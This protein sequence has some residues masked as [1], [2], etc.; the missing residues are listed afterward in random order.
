MG[1]GGPKTAGPPE[2][3]PPRGLPRSLLATNCSVTGTRTY[4]TSSSTI[5]VSAGYSRIAILLD[6]LSL[7]LRFPARLP[8]IDNTRNFLIAHAAIGSQEEHGCS[9]DHA[10]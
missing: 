10:L 8:E 6:K 2:S 7:T 3:S 5:H 4:V 9:K 1:S